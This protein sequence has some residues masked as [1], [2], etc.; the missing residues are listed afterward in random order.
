[1]IIPECITLKLRLQWH[2]VRS[3]HT[4]KAHK[5]SLAESKQKLVLSFMLMYQPPSCCS[6]F[7]RAAMCLLTNLKCH[8]PVNGWA[9]LL[10]DLLLVPTVY[11]SFAGHLLCLVRC[12][13]DCPYIRVVALHWPHICAVNGNHSQSA[14]FQ[15]QFIQKFVKVA[16]NAI[17]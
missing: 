13:S 7:I 11:V 12:C 8:S 14:I 2:V 6:M 5:N 17:I 9:P 15:L 10:I 3:V 16:K 4:R 1:M